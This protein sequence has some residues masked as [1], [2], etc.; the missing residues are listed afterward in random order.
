MTLAVYS[1]KHRRILVEVPI[2]RDVI[3]D[4]MI[5][6]A[7]LN[8]LYTGALRRWREEARATGRQGGPQWIRIIVEVSTRYDH[9]WVDL[10]S[11]SLIVEAQLLGPDAAHDVDANLGDYWRRSH[12]QQRHPSTVYTCDILRQHLGMDDLIGQLQL[13]KGRWMH[14]MWRPVGYEDA[15]PIGQNLTAP[16]SNQ[17]QAVCYTRDAIFW[18]C[19]K[20]RTLKI[21]PRITAPSLLVDMEQAGLFRGAGSDDDKVVGFV[22][23]LLGL[24]RCDDAL[25]VVKASITHPDLKES[26]AH[27][28]HAQRQRRT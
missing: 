26:M 4:S 2:E 13:C 10:S 28:C 9:I 3:K 8:Y 16:H 27:M 1:R 20:D 25:A 11:T 5:D 6:D 12:E 17:L 18:W 7:E 22:R 21:K 14:E 19:L 23:H 24:N 15:D